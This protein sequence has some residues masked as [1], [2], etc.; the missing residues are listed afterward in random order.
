MA[1]NF[2]SI[3]V[4]LA[5][6]ISTVQIARARPQAPAAGVATTDIGGATAAFDSFTHVPVAPVH[7]AAET[8]FLPINN[9][10]PIVN[11]LPTNVNDFSGMG[12]FDVP[13]FGAGAPGIGL[14][15]GAGVAGA[16]DIT[17]GTVAG[18]G[19]GAM[20]GPAAGMF[21][22]AGPGSSLLSAGSGL[23]GPTVDPTMG[24]AGA[25][26]GIAAGGLAGPTGGIATP[27]VGIVPG[28]LAAAPAGF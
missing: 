8:D 24:L 17:A 5:M 6:V 1:P 16:G 12:P 15:L 10:L 22:G 23:V 25:F 27:G 9:V 2:K 26:G 4:S 28:A 7:I 21:L 18:V 11:V 20:Q 19:L 14:G 13:L 3:L